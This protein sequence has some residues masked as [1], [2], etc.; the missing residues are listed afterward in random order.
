MTSKRKLPSPITILMAFIIIAALATIVIP[1]GQY[2]RLSYTEGDKFTFITKDGESSLPFTQHTLDSLGIKIS[3]DKFK[4]GAIRKPVSVP[5]TYQTIARN[6]QGLIEIL[7]API[8]GV[9]DSIDIVFFILVIGGFMSVF[10]ESGSMV[11]GLTALSYNMK[12][13]E[14]WLIIILTFLFSF[15]GASYGMAEETLVF[16]PVIVPL[17]LA[18]GYDLLVPVA[19]IFAGA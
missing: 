14:T 7:Q 4:S 16:Y 18:A 19:V 3:L 8:K 10:N 6:R 9:Y 11:R 15:A 13:K 12:G 2:S 1:A 17:F 5:G